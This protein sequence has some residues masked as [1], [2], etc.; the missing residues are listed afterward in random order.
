MVWVGVVVGAAVGKLV[1]ELG[2]RGDRAA[3][4]F[5][6]VESVGAAPTPHRSVQRCSA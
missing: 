2:T 3:A 4:L 6:I 5:Q 1:T